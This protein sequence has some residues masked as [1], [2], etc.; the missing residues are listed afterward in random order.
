MLM[1]R[2]VRRRLLIAAMIAIVGAAGLGG[3]YA[4]LQHRK[5]N[6]ARASYAKGLG[7]LD[8]GKYEEALHSVGRYVQRYPD[9]LEALSKYGN[10]RERVPLPNNRH[11]VEA[12]KVHL[13]V[14]NEA[15][16]NLAARHELIRLYELT[17]FDTELLH[18]SEQ[19]LGKA[20]GDRRALYGRAVALFRLATPARRQDALNAVTQY[21]EAAPNDLKGHLLAF[22]IM[23]GTSEGQSRIQTWIDEME[24]AQGAT[25]R[26]LILRSISHA[27]R[28]DFGEAK[29]L[30]IKAAAAEGADFDEELVT[31]F[32]SHCDRL[33]LFEQT[34][35]MLDKFAST[36]KSPTAYT[37]LLRRLYMAGAYAKAA[38]VPVTASNV[39]ALFLKGL[40]S[41]ESQEMSGVTSA[42]QSLRSLEGK[43]NPAALADLLELLSQPRRE[44]TD[45]L[46][47]AQTVSIADPSNVCA[48]LYVADGL[49][50]L[51]EA[52]SALNV[53][54]RIANQEPAW[55]TPVSKI[56]E[57]AADNGRYADGQQ[58]ARKAL[59]R[60]P[61]DIL[62]LLQ[63]ARCMAKDISLAN[64]TPLAEVLQTL[65]QVDKITAADS[66]RRFSTVPIRVNALV[67]AGKIEEAKQVVETMLGASDN[68]ATATVVM[69]VLLESR[70]LGS[71]VEEQVEAY[72]QERFGFAPDLVAHKV[73]RLI[74]NGQKEQAVKLV[75]DAVAQA[76]PEEALEWKVLHAKVLDD[77]GAP[78]ALEAW[79]TLADSFSGNARVQWYALAS[80]SARTD[81]AFEGRLIERIGEQSE[82]RGTNWK[83]ARAQWLMRGKESQKTA[84]AAVILSDLVKA[85]PENTSARLLLAECMLRLNQQTSATEQVMAASDIDPH[86]ADHA[87]SAARMLLQRGDARR[88]VTYLQR[89]LFSAAATDPQRLEAANAMASLGA[90]VEALRALQQAYPDLNAQVERNGGLALLVAKLSMASGQLD[91]VER[92]C[93][94]L[95]RVGSAEAL[96]FVASYYASTGRS[97]AAAVQMQRIEQAAAPE[98]QKALIRA[99]YQLRFGER[100]KAL[101]I[102]S[103]A[104]TKNASDPVL[105]IQKIRATAGIQ[106]IDA[107]L[108]EGTAARDALPND[109]AIRQFVELAPEA[110]KVSTTWPE[111][112]EIALDVLDDPTLGQQ[113]RQAL[114]TMSELNRGGS[115]A[116]R[117]GKLSRLVVQLDRFPGLYKATIRTLLE[118]NQV[119][120]AASTASLA[121]GR[122]PQDPKLAEQA[123]LAYSLAGRW[124][125]AAAAANEWRRRADVDTFAPDVYLAS[126]AARM[127]D[128]KKASESLQ[129]YLKNRTDK[130]RYEAAAILM[131]SLQLASNQL[132]EAEKLLRPEL[133][134]GASWRAG[135]IQLASDQ[136]ADLNISRR[137]LR[138]V[139]ESIDPSAAE[140]HALLLNAWM[141]L[142]ERGG[143][144]ED[145]S[146]AVRVANKLVAIGNVPIP[147]LVGAAQIK[148][149]SG[150]VDGAVALYRKVLASEPREPIAS[151][152]LAMILLSQKK[153]LAQA[154]QLATVASEVIG[155]PN[156]VDFLDT[157]STAL[158]ANGHLERAA[159]TAAQALKA[160]GNRPELHLRRIDWLAQLGRTREASS[161]LKEFQETRASM[162][163]LTDVEQRQLSELEIKVPAGT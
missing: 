54:K 108:R 32:A 159:Q 111:A 146:E 149:V 77:V 98:G 145:V 120:E 6:N 46:K 117:A 62:G 112:V 40:C 130:K 26:T 142:R 136:I 45:L 42:T 106:G 80:R 99:Q 162:R 18:M 3:T 30:A 94:V 8:A 37:M 36:Q 118:A 127:G 140:E 38:A 91:Q 59:E 107:A 82:L 20:P 55:S 13:R 72:Y 160:D 22:E 116:E 89:A 48:Q 143:G 53:Y 76:K 79:K 4:Y 39:Q 2:K 70:A 19:T 27:Y 51:G 135:W 1:Q 47:R 44:P 161:A 155:H 121:S 85:Q 65:D 86:S 125:E 105:W 12:M 33:G 56:A 71:S 10:L 151:N 57:L 17:G 68:A 122:F 35:A 156:H 97:D 31:V 25:L 11:L 124:S 153:D 64:T 129:P 144:S 163:A 78:G 92:V 69:S 7:Q 61:Q 63:L 60:N 83:I 152:N 93:P 123:T 113:A 9:D 100:E 49:L 15:P 109:A 58:L 66:M 28:G 74:T 139:E 134:T 138:E 148:E 5:N 101:E 73:R 29:A 75:A 132:D 119:T 158:S 154:E 147:Y 141:K 16:D 96:A 103:A 50:G 14:L 81:Y 21:V 115:P 84:E 110:K 43:E 128:W 52:E 34:L 102:L 131:A 24:K 126:A 133:A 87:L 67:A 157:L 41:I 150:D 137:W 88:A 90:P 104:L 23:R 114:L 95:E